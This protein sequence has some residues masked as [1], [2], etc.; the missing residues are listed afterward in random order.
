MELYILYIILCRKFL[1]FSFYLLKW[2]KYHWGITFM[3]AWGW[4]RGVQGEDYS[5][6]R[7]GSYSA[8]DDWPP[9][10][11]L[12]FPHHHTSSPYYH[13]LM[14]LNQNWVTKIL[15]FFLTIPS[16]HLY[17]TCPS[18]HSHTCTLYNLSTFHPN[19]PALTHGSTLFRTHI[20]HIDWPSIHLHFFL[21]GHVEGWGGPCCPWWR[22]KAHLLIHLRLDLADLLSFLFHLSDPCCGVMVE[23]S[24]KGM[25]N[26]LQWWDWADQVYN[27]GF[28]HGELIMYCQRGKNTLFCTVTCGM[29]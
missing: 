6:I 25:W 29:K 11:Q 17:S 21:Q 16:L 10:I 23:A 9:S 28:C 22:A 1:K 15:I 14:D 4:G 26:D 5:S 7:S 12:C 27:I 3:R 20:S 8:L 24:V 13:N 18:P 19:L 2:I